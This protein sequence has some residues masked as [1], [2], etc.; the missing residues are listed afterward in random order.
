MMEVEVNVKKIYMR[1]FDDFWKRLTASYADRVRYSLIMKELRIHDYRNFFL[2]VGCGTGVLCI[3]VAINGAE[4]IGLDISSANLVK[5][6]D[7]ARHKNLQNCSFILGDA[8]R[9]PFKENSFDKIVCSEV[10]EHFVKQNTALREISRVAKRETEVIMTV[11]NLLYPW[12][13]LGRG[14]PSITHRIKAFLVGIRTGFVN[15]AY[16]IESREVAPYHRVFSPF[17][18]RNNVS[19]YFKVKKIESTLKWRTEFL[20]FFPVSLQ[21][22]FVSSS[23]NTP[24]IKYFGLQV[25]CVATSKKDAC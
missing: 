25:L 24:I 3:Y 9:L 7:M 11:P 15:E 10:L 12:R 23:L 14:L 5:A 2:D 19:L 16:S 1:T 8:E 20:S 17:F 21:K 4:V 18:F 22:V 13:W 6:K